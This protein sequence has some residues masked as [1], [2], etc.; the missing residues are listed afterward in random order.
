MNKNEL[1]AAMAAESGLSKA[2]TEK[3]LNALIVTHSK[4]LKRFHFQK[5]RTLLQ[6]GAKGKPENSRMVK[7][8]QYARE[9][10]KVHQHCK[11]QKVHLG[12]LKFD[13]ENN[14]GKLWKTAGK[15]GYQISI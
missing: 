15:H 12:K 4:T 1:I 13:I 8:L 3:A 9:V 11:F 2:D 7:A 6:D 5:R 10:L 14:G